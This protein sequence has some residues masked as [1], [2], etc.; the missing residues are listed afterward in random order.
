MSFKVVKYNFAFNEPRIVIPM[1]V[2]EIAAYIKPYEY[3]EE[4]EKIPALFEVLYNTDYI[5]IFM[6]IENYFDTS[7]TLLNNL[8]NDFIEYFNNN[9]GILDSKLTKKYVLTENKHS[10]HNGRSFH[11]IFTDKKILMPNLKKL[12][13]GFVEKNT[14]Y[15][16]IID[17][18]VYSNKR[19]FRL[20]LQHSA[21]GLAKGEEISFKD[22][23]YK[24]SEAW[25]K[26]KTVYADNNYH[27]Y[28]ELNNRTPEGK[29]SDYIIQSVDN[30]SEIHTQF[31][32][33]K[34]PKSNDFS[35]NYFMRNKYN[36]NVNVKLD[37]EPVTKVI[38]EGI[39]SVI[40][41]VVQPK[42]DVLTDIDIKIKVALKSLKY[43]NAVLNE[44]K[45]LL[46]TKLNEHFAKNK[47]YEGFV[48]D[49][50]TLTKS[51]VYQLVKI[52]FGISVE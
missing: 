20:P 37:L 11:L 15:E 12:I 26:W 52:V 45:Q 42:Q 41:S 34:I 5:K 48:D 14:Q 27:D 39:S 28:Y 38:T 24:T 47:T 44:Q 29:L 6:D 25:N 18:S 35:G 13:C 33:T 4:W 9:K 10:R 46:L 51:E 36:N 50:S 17:V 16:K 2:N 21:C 1:D 22:L 7:D 31:T 32:C 43:S 49:D 8:I 40:N 19:L 23:Y 30:C 3:K